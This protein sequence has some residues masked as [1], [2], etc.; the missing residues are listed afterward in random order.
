MT[1]SF[2]SSGTSVSMLTQENGRVELVVAQVNIVPVTSAD[3]GNFDVVAR[4]AIGTI[5][6]ENVSTMAPAEIIE[7]LR[8]V[9]DQLEAKENGTGG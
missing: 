8:Y 5:N 3:V 4:A 9:A 7:A 6:D 1:P 2:R